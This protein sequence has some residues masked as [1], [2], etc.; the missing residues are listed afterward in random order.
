MRSQGL[1]GDSAEMLDSRDAFLGTGW[2]SALRDAVTRVVSAETPHT[3]VDF[4]CGTGYY[5]AG[6]L[7]QTPSARA[8]AVDISPA[9][10]A[11]TVRAL[12]HTDGLVAN[13]WSPLP[14]RDGAADVILNVFAPRNAAEFARVLRPGG[15]LVVVI[16]QP[17]HLRELREAG[18]ALGVQDDKAAVLIA[19]L[20]AHF[21]VHSRQQLSTEVWL[22]VT[23]IAALVG[24]GPS[25][26]HRSTAAGRLD[27]AERHPVTTA[28]EVFG[29]RRLSH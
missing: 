27:P 22:T 29:F 5:L 25:A 14:I 1:I 11:R 2:Y 3:V 13:V 21:T 19:G 18:L 4:G 9:A 8:L 15:L 26:H 7:D 12:E 20:A 23:E 24:M 28:F 16:P 6:I 10:V 17:S